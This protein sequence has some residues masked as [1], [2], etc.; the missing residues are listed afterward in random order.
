MP[1][2]RIN[3]LKTN[4]INQFVNAVYGILLGYGFS[5]AMREIKDGTDKEVGVIFSTVSV[6]FVIIVICIYWWDWIKNIGHNIEN[7]YREFALDMAILVSLEWLFFVYEYPI[8]FCGIFL[9]LSIL[10]LLWVKNYHK[11]KY[12]RSDLKS[13]KQYIQQNYEVKQYIRNRWKGVLLFSF[14]LITTFIVRNTIDYQTL[15]ISVFGDN[16]WNK[17]LIGNWLELFLIISI[18]SFNRI[19]FF[20]HRVI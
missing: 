10:S 18:Y 12:N 7:D 19:H 8:Y 20:K 13:W 2:N 11:T 1:K 14:C 4:F 5:N 6:L 17:Y 16:T 3:D 15:F 9:L